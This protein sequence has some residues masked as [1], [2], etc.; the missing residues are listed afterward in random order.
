MVNMPA[1]WVLLSGNL[2]AMVALYLWYYRRSKRR[3]DQSKR[4]LQVTYVGLAM[5]IIMEMT[6]AGVIVVR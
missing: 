5:A 1:L 2:L 3:R 4:R 6:I